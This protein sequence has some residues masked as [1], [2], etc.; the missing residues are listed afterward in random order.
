MCGH[1]AG[2]TRGTV[3]TIG[4]YLA[5]FRSAI[6]GYDL[7]GI[8]ILSLYNSGSMLNPEEVPP[9]ALRAMIADIRKHVSIRKL[10]LETR[11][12]YVDQSRL[13]DL[14]DILG[15]ERILSVAIGLE[16]ADDMKRSLCINKGSSREEISRAV[17][18]MRGIGETQLYVLLGLPFLTEAEAVEDTLQSIRCARDLGAD[19]IHIEPLTLQRYTLIEYLHT[20]GLYRL[21]SLYS[22]YAVLE[23]VVPEIQPYVSPFLHMPLPEDIPS[24]CPSCTPG[25]IENLLGRYNILRTRESLLYPRCA[26]LPLWEE[27]MSERDPRP[28]ARRIS[29]ALEI[30]A[31]GKAP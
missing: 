22:I 10:V 21:P 26:C 6:S 11:A 17:E 9:E 14:K 8:E 19:E 27:R 2:T 4:E 29:D 20:A 13:A 23:A 12:E 7:S 18:K 3:P 1:H 30:L 16:T 24:G 25:L 28:L 15:T 31:E 5:Q